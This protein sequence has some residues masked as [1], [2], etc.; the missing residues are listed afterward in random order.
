M[1]LNILVSLIPVHRTLLITAGQVDSISV[2]GTCSAPQVA[3]F[4]FLV[5]ILNTFSDILP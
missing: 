1:T 4:L 5:Q 2:T 3:M